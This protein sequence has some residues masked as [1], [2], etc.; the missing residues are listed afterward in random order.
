[1][2]WE[3]IKKNNFL[4]DCLAC[5]CNVLLFCYFK[6]NLKLYLVFS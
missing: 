4:F 6:L 3:F 5:F 2:F 1:M